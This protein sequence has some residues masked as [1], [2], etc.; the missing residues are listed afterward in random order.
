MAYKLDGKPIAYGTPFKKGD[1]KYTRAWWTT[2]NTSEKKSLGVTEVADSTPAPYDARFYINASTGKPIADLK[3]EWVKLQKEQA[4][5]LLGDTDWMVLRAAGGGTA[6]PSATTT[7]R[8]NIRTV[9][10]ERETQI[11][12]AAN[13]AALKTL[14]DA[15]Q[16]IA[17]T[18]DNGATEKKDG[19][20]NSYDPKQYEQVQNPAGLKAWP[21]A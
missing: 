1:F 10:G 17:G 3:A 20:G 8:A 5:K 19:S 7:K 13:V 21:T 14:I 12:A 16:T 4:G 11:N 2:T 15:A 6:V 18:A 9:S